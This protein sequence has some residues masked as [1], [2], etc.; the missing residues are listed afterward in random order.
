L[1][2]FDNQ[3]EASIK[4]RIDFYRLTV[5]ACIY[6]HCKL[7]TVVNFIKEIYDDDDDDDAI[8]I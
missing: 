6:C 2:Y 5:S 8:A 3:T 4:I 7:V 1:S